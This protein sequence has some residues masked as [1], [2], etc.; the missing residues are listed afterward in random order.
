MRRNIF[1]YLVDDLLI[2]RADLL[3]MHY[4]SVQFIFITNNGFFSGDINISGLQSGIRE[5]TLSYN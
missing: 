1:Y 5:F 3:S 4:S 2:N